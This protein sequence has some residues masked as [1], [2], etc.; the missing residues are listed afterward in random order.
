MKI[1]QGTL[2][3][4]LIVAALAAVLPFVWMLFASFKGYAEVTSSYALLPIEW[5]LDNYREII[6]RVGFLNAF[7][8][9]ALVAIPNTAMIVFTSTAAGY[10]FAK[11][12]FWGKE[13]LF[14]ALLA[15]MMVPFAV[16]VIPLFLTMRDLGLI[17]KLGGVVVTSVCSTF[18][19]FMMRQAIE[20]IPNDYIDAARVD[21]ASEAWILCQVIAPLVLASMSTLAVFT[22]LGSWD[23]YMWPSLIL[24]SNRNHTL[25]IVIAGMRN[26]YSSRYQLWAAGSMLTVVP[27]MILFTFAQKQFVSGLAMT[28]LK[29]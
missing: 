13:T 27:V 28:G 1:Y 17:D 9:S 24:K 8:N 14:T 5:T 4:V 25:P 20:A 18:G 7:K 19:I 6:E 11:Y 10:V 12:D 2:H 22:F 3:V 21:G 23:S 29:G 16:V 15:T 26:L